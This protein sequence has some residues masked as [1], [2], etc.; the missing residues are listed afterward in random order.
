MISNTAKINNRRLSKDASIK[1][2]KDIMDMNPI[3]RLMLFIQTRRYNKGFKDVSFLRF[4]IISRLLAFF[5]MKKLSS[6]LQKIWEELYSPQIFKNHSIK[7]WA[8]RYN[9]YIIELMADIV[10][11]IPNH[12]M[13]FFNY[14]FNLEGYNHIEKSLQKERGVLIPTIHLGEMFHIVSALARK[15]VTIQGKIQRVEVVII[16]SPEYEYIFQDIIKNNENLYVPVTGK[17]DELGPIIEDHL[18]NNRC[19]VLM[20]DYFKKN[21]FRVPFI[22]GS[23]S[24]NFLIPC[25]RLLSYLHLKCGSPIV[26]ALSF[27]IH[28]LKHSKIIFFE[29]IN[30][31]NINLNQSKFTGE[32][33][34]DIQKYRSDEL[35]EKKKVAL[36]ALLINQRLYPFALKFPFYWQVIYTFQKRS[37]FRI[38][39][40]DISTYYEFFSIII[41]RLRDLILKSYEPG[42]LDSQILSVLNEIQNKI[43]PLKKDENPNIKIEIKHKYIEIGRLTAKRAFKKVNS[44]IQSIQNSYIK[45]SYPEIVQLLNS[46]F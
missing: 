41:T 3:F 6:G 32:I 12:N 35:N 26:P 17:S 8:Y 20:Q 19:V 4:Q 7:K 11:Y 42:R 24:Y 31:N 27:P 34:K 40:K 38:E 39:F 30:L 14:F 22:Y 1:V 21:Q 28:N 29:P 2:H 13:K 25:P 23:K 44:I 16:G 9:A 46:A 37:S 45:S 36:L 10:Y 43:E 18:K 5:V 15:S 33:R